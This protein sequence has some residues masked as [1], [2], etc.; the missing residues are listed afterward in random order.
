[1]QSAY[2]ILH[3]HLQTLIGSCSY[4]GMETKPSIPEGHR[5]IIICTDQRVVL[6]GYAPNDGLTNEQM[7]KSGAVATLKRARM[8]V[9]W[10]KA[11][12]GVFGLAS[13]GPGSSCRVGPPATV[14]SKD[15]HAVLDVESPEAVDRWESAPWR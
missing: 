14:S 5:P 8:C 9:Y 15:I 12:R 13:S 10:G 1:M 4:E 3:K 11:E 7:L 6:F 2:N